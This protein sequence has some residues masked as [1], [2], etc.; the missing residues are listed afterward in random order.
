MA[1]GAPATAALLA[2]I[3]VVSLLGLFVWPRIIE[4]ALLRP[5][6]LARRHDYGTLITSGFVHA[7]LGH[8]L[9]NAFTLWSFGF[10]LE[11]HLGTGPYVALYVT[12]LLA[13]SIATWLIHRN[14]PE[15]ASLGAS[16]AILAV[17]FASIIAFPKA[18]LIIF[19]IPM[20]IPAPLF[21]IGYLA[22]SVYASKSRAGRINHDAHIA[23]AVTGLVFMATFDEG[24]IG[25]AIGAWMP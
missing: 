22:Y 9:F 10:R 17:L 6:E 3:A 12:G 13:S 23:G 20:P 16:G 11:H 21:A 14:R 18:S 24:S 2:A 8:L 25:R 19:P 5:Y 15:Y 1:A 7:D 4:L